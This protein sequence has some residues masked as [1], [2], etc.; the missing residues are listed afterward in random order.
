MYNTVDKFVEVADLGFSC[1]PNDYFLKTLH[2]ELAELS[3]DPFRE[4]DVDSKVND[5]KVNDR[6]KTSFLHPALVHVR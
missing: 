1:C 3:D 5:S 6:P 4:I 2:L